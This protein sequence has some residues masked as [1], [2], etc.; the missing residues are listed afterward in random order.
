MEGIEKN[1]ASCVLEY[2]KKINSNGC[3]Q[4]EKLDESVLSAAYKTVL[5]SRASRL[6][7]DLKESVGF[8]EDIFSKVL[9]EF[10]EGNKI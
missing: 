2:L 8:R 7:N 10:K 5:K 1:D 3:K 4:R 6:I 9:I